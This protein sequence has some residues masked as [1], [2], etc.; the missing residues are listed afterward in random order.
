MTSRR[1]AHL[2]TILQQ[3]PL[4]R[5]VLITRS[6]AAG[7][8]WLER[9]CRTGKAVI[10][11]EIATPQSLIGHSARL[12]LS[13]KGVAEL[14]AEDAFWAVHRFMHRIAVE[15]PEPYVPLQLLSPGV[16]GCFLSAI[17][18]LRHAMI[19]SEHL[20]PDSFESMPKGRYVRRLLELYEEYLAR[21][22]LADAAEMRHYVE[23]DPRQTV[24]LMDRHVRLSAAE[25][26]AL[27][28]ITG[29][30]LTMLE[31]DAAFTMPESDFP[32]QHMEFF[33][34][35]GPVSEVRE[36]FRRMAERRIPPDQAELIVSNA[37]LY[38][39]AVYTT[40][41]QYDIPCIYSGGI[42]IDYSV[43]GQAVRLFLAWLESGYQ[44]DWILLALKQGILRPPAAE[45]SI[46]TGSYIR[47]LEKS[48]IGWGRDR[49]DI[50]TQIVPQ[51]LNEIAPDAD[52]VDTTPAKRLADW[53]QNWFACLPEDDAAW[54]PSAVA[55]GIQLML[56]S[57][58]ARGEYE[59]VAQACIR[60][61]LETL[62][63]AD[64]GTMD[65]PMAIRFV[66]DKIE[67]LTFGGSGIPSEG[68]LQVASLQDG[69]Q[70]GRPYTFIIGMDERSWALASS[71][72]PILLDE[73]RQRISSRL[74]TAKARAEQEEQA[75]AER[76]G[77]IRGQCTMS[78]SSY[79]IADK[80][81]Q[82][83]AFELLQCFR[84][85]SG[86]ETAGYEDLH[87][88]LPQAA[89]VLSS[90]GRV[91]IDAQE[92]WL[93]TLIGGSRTIR[94][95]LHEVL[96]A[97]PSL[98]AGQLALESRMDG[99]IG[100]YDGVFDPGPYE[101]VPA[102]TSVSK[103]EL[104]ARCPLQYFYQEIL[105]VRPKEPA[106]FD[107]SRWLDAAQR[108]TLLHEIY[109]RYWAETN[110]QGG[111]HDRTRLERITEQALQKAVQEIPA[112]S[113]H[114]MLKECE[115]IRRDAAIFWNSEQS[116][117]SQPRFMELE[118]HG[119]DEPFTVELGEGLTLSLRGYIDRIDELE[120]HTYKILDYKTGSSRKYREDG[121]FAGGTQL[122]H[123]VYAAAAQQWLRRSG[124]DPEAKVVEAGYYFPTFRGQGHE[125]TRSQDRAEDTARLI[126]RMLEAMRRGIF[127]PTKDA[128]Q[129]SWCEYREVCGPH[130]EWM[131]EKRKD[132]DRAAPLNPLTEVESYA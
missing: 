11:I 29:G 114:V 31:A 26:E 47:V 79:R 73:E 53:F 30:R 90:G 83:A 92:V 50:L 20:Q 129:C 32:Y 94:A 17:Q 21:H 121:Y 67:R 8:Q 104:F 96:A 100:P 81:E 62:R 70:T 105:R 65:R 51:A 34:A 91:P 71:Q 84:L 113:E 68:R 123:A 12:P 25:R 80:Q 69:G 97:Y 87:H 58:P 28:T 98:H 2:E 52:P 54:S 106:E 3:F 57:V 132:P 63:C 128:R 107:R 108:G 61:M 1:L 9:L 43:T 85:Q 4:Q 122:Q 89:G 88:A 40:A 119:E 72:D 56:Q 116:R 74:E 111:S 44:L 39:S 102:A 7:H 110:E 76:L 13:E 86:R 49:Y 24:Y 75:R 95:G 45:E 127:P 115:H 60:Q 59:A 19:R 22:R 35:H 109:Q 131:K 42:P 38:T 6:H 64:T 27:E 101:P 14:N 55:V 124:L 36:V 37:G 103:L 125:I 41:L 112:P 93:K 5:K 130:A 33:H 18:E 48:G 66:R 126:G 120:P 10:N 16:V 99:E 15:E 117:T 82:N 78:Y 118:L 46:S 77:A 23:P